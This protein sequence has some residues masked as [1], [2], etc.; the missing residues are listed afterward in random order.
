M[1]LALLL[2]AAPGCSPSDPPAAAPAECRVTQAA[3]AQGALELAQSRNQREWLNTWLGVPVLQFP[4]DLMTY[5]ALLDEVKPDFVIESGTALGGLSVYLA[6]VLE[7]VNP[8]A[9]VLSID[10]ND[11]GRT[12]VL[13]QDTIRDALKERI[14]FLQGSSTSQ[15]IFAAISDRVRDRRVLVILDSLHTERHVLAELRLYAPLV[16][17]GS[18][19]VVNDTHW[20][21]LEPRANAAGP[22]AAVRAFL[23][24]DD[25]FVADRTWERYMISC[26]HGGVLKRIR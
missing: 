12:K 21:S 20:D 5:Q 15:E 3:L 4:T 19:I 14:V 13:A 2:A 26:F 6:T 24:T 7:N 1:V 11:N 22:L 8:A 23:A 16:P 17:V 25:R 18:Y 9:K 10:I